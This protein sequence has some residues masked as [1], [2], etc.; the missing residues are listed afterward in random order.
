MQCAWPHLEHSAKKISERLHL[1]DIAIPKT[2]H[3]PT[4]RVIAKKIDGP[5]LRQNFITMTKTFEIIV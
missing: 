3:L 2:K 5:A 4:S 1:L